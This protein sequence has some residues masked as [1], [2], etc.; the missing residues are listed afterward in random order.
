[1]DLPTFKTHLR[2]FL[3]HFK[4]FSVDDNSG[5]FSEKTEE[6]KLQQEKAVLT[7]RSAIPGML[8]PPE[9]DSDF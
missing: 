2:D 6:A 4:E 1:M 5:L 9:I 8:K 7:E 3:I